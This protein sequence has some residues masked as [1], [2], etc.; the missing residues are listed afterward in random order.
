MEDLEDIQ[1]EM[2]F[3]DIAEISKERFRNI[4]FKHIKEH[5]FI[6][7][8]EKKDKRVSE[9]ARGKL[10]KY[11]DL[12]M[13]EYLMETSINLTLNERKWIFKCRTNDLDLKANFQWKH[14]NIWCISCKTDSPETNEH[15]LECSTLLGANEIVSYIPEYEELFSKDQDEVLYISRV[16]KEN[17]QNRKQYLKQ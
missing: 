5:A 6:E 15:L 10:I 9:Y 1:L 14:E 12:Y 8:I 4:V 11:E 3:N 16:L 17:F 2:N 7:L 13:Q